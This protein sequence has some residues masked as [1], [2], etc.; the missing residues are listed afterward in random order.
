MGNCSYHRHMESARPKK[1]ATY[2]DDPR[3]D[4]VNGCPKNVNERVIVL[5]FKSSIRIVI[6]SKNTSISAK[7]HTNVTRA[8]ILFYIP[9]YPLIPRLCILIDDLKHYRMFLI[10]YII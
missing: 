2:V 4:P 9:T 6:L 7:A 3:T 8:H 5:C 10:K 1:T